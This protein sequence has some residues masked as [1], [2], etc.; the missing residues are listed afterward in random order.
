MKLILCSCVGHC[1]AGDPGRQAIFSLFKQN[2]GAEWSVVGEFF[3][4]L[5]EPQGETDTSVE[6]IS[7][8]RRSTSVKQSRSQDQSDQVQAASKCA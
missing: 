4:N 6:V 5:T 2:L 7:R 8:S 3:L 1:V